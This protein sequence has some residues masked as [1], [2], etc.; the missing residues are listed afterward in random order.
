M[1]RFLPA[2]PDGLPGFAGLPPARR[3]DSAVCRAGP[4]APGWFGGR[5]SERIS[6]EAAAGRIRLAAVRPQLPRVAVVLRWWEVLLVAR[7]AVLPDQQELLGQS[8]A[9]PA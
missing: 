3:P 6:S 9:P 1:C 5:L 7:A 4:R 8:A 2:P